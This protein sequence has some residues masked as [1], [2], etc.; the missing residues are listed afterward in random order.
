MSD[1]VR[2]SSLGLMEIEG[3]IMVFGR[4]ESI[5]WFRKYAYG[6]KDPEGPIKV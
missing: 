2:Q 1:R 6:L 4:Q 3:P 5:E